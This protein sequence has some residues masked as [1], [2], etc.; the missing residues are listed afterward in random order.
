MIDPVEAV[1]V[2]DTG[3][4]IEGAATGGG[5]IGDEPSIKYQDQENQ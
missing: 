1:E 3:E 2:V 4:A 5:I